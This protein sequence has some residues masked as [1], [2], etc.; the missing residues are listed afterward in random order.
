[1]YKLEKRRHEGI[2]YWRK[3]VGVINEEGRDFKTTNH[4][5]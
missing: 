3:R 5:H 2:N 4:K 1:M